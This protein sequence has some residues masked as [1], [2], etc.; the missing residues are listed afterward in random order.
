MEFEIA[1][2]HMRDYFFVMLKHSDEKVLT[3]ILNNLR[4]ILNVFTEKKEN[5]KS[6][7]IIIDL[8]L[9]RKYFSKKWQKNFPN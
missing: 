1:H 3:A 4:T 8:Y 6:V 9:F 2:E 7:I 5:P